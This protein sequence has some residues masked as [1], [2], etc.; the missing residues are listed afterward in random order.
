V[1]SFLRNAS[2]A[3]FAI[4]KE[5]WP[6]MHALASRA[7]QHPAFTAL[8]RFEELSLH[9]PPLAQRDALI[10]AGAPVSPQSHTA[11]APEPGV[12]AM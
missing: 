4:D 9:T 12:R 1:G 11:V 10:A 2:V 5:R 6:A 7:L 8:Q 3:G